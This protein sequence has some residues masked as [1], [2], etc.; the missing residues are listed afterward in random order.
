VDARH[1]D[2][3]VSPPELL[4]VQRPR[5]MRSEVHPAVRHN[6]ARLRRRVVT[7]IG[8]G[9][10]GGHLDARAPPF[11]QDTAK[12]GP[13]HGGTTEVAGADEQDIHGRRGYCTCIL[14]PPGGLPPPGYD[15]GEWHG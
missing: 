12:D 15:K 9:P 1:R 7:G 10:R 14:V 3:Q 8:P 11:R 13:G 2:H 5:P 6:G 4:S